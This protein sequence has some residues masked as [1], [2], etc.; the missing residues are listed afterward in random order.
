MARSR[1]GLHGTVKQPSWRNGGVKDIP[2]IIIHFV[3]NFIPTQA[4]HTEPLPHH[5]AGRDTSVDSVSPAGNTIHPEF[6]P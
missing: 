1:G 3:G 4:N 2:T 6:S 5:G